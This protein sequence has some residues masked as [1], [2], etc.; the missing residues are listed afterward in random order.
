MEYS[1]NILHILNKLKFSEIF[2][3]C[4]TYFY[5]TFY[6]TPL[7]FGDKLFHTYFM[8]IKTVSIEKLLNIRVILNQ[9][10]TLR[11]ISYQF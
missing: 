7:E 2:F 9:L 3:T 8:I 11:F 10:L 6:S 5:Y 1:Y 4:F